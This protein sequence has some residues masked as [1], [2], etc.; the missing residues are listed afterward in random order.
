MGFDTGKVLPVN[1]NHIDDPFFGL[2][3][4]KPILQSI[5]CPEESSV[6][7][8]CQMEENPECDNEFLALECAGEEGDASGLT[9]SA[10]EQVT[11]P[12]LGLL[13]LPNPIIIGCEQTLEGPTLF[14]GDPGSLYL[15]GC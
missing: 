7:K 8:D 11:N 9:V 4:G 2:C 3:H 13:P 15:V 10:A 1:C 14:P 6:L 12:Q 5:S